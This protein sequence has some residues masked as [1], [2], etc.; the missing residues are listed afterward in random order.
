MCPNNGLEVGRED[1]ESTGDDHVLLTINQNKKT[2]LIQVANV[3]GTHKRAPPI[4]KPHHGLGRLWAVVVTA[5]HP[6][7][8]ARD[9]THLASAKY[10][11]LII[12]DADIETKNRGAYG[13][14]F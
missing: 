2:I 10:L 13:M 7:T 14:E 5:Q 9:F 8:V 4:I 1:V 11:T 6:R 3:T 12:N